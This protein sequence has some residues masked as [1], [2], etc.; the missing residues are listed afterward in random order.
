MKTIVTILVFNDVEVLD[1]AGPLDV[2]SLANEHRNRELLDIKITAKDKK[3]IKRAPDEQAILNR[4]N[5]HRLG[6]IQRHDDK[7]FS[8]GG[9]Q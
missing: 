2:F 6:S 1:L 8:A 5:N 3:A 9:H 7:G 4:R